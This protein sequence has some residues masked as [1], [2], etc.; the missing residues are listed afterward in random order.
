MTR[1]ANGLRRFA[2]PPP[3]PSAAPEPERCGLC[4]EIVGE[5]HGHLV[6]TQQRSIVCACTACG[7]LFTRQAGLRQGSLDSRYRTVP[8]R[9][10]H[11]PAAPLSAAEW[12]ELAIPVSIAF[13]FENS[14]LGHVVASYPSPAG[15]TECE[16]DLAAWERMADSHP[17]LRALVP[18][19]EA[20]LVVGRQP[21]RD[22]TGR[23][24][25]GTSGGG[26]ETFLIPIDLCY[27][28]AGLLRLNWHGFDGG[29]EVAAIL[30][31]FLDDLRGRSRTLTADR[32]G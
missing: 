5:R 3:Q 2:V 14:A 11:D 6:D 10:R 9:V 29:T 26:I 12:D 16:L 19:V 20:I 23:G 4:G 8:D 31:G 22:F 21:G 18:D 32:E 15:V 28:L 13:F 7:L 24:D 17:L 1:V 25:P 27:S 30:A